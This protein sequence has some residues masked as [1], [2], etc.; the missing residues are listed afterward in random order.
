MNKYF[1]SRKELKKL[2]ASDFKHGNRI[3]IGKYEIE[4]IYHNSNVK[5]NRPSLLSTLIDRNTFKYCD[6][7][8]GQ[9]RPYYIDDFL[10]K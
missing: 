5:Y 7:T 9:G 6:C 2:R 10:S 1:F 3:I 4:I 8:P